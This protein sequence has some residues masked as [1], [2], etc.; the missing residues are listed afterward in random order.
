MKKTFLF[1][2]FLVFSFFVM[3]FTGCDDS[4]GSTTYLIRNG[5]QAAGG[6]YYETGV[7]VSPNGSLVPSL[8][9]D[10]R[11][12]GNSMADVESLLRQLNFNNSWIQSVKNNLNGSGSAFVFYV[13]TS[14]YYRWLWITKE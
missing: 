8:I 3:T 2:L 1:G 6:G 13:N 9:E 7:Y 5:G 14:S 11:D 4:L 12:S 10:G